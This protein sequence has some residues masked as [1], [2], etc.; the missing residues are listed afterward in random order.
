[1]VKILQRDVILLV[2]VRRYWRK[3]A[4]IPLLLMSASSFSHGIHST[5]TKSST[6]TWTITYYASNP[7]SRLAFRRN[8]DD[9][10]TRRWKPIDNS[11]QIVYENLEEF[12]TRKDGRTF[13]QVSF[14]LTPTYTQ[15]P[16]DYAPFSPYSD[17]GVLVYSGRFFACE[18]KCDDLLNEWEFKLLAPKNDHVIL[19]GKKVLSEATWTD[20]NSGTN[21]Y[22]GQQ[23]P[24]HT[25]GFVALIDGGL[26]DKIRNS[27]F[28]DIPRLTAYF[29]SR[30]GEIPDGITPSLFASY[31]NKKGS[32]VQGGVLPN[33]IFIHWDKENL[34][35][36]ADDKDFLN[37]LLWTFAHEVAH[38]YQRLNEFSLK[39]SES[40]IY[41]GHAELLA[42]DALRHLYPLSNLYRNTKI[43]SF[44]KRCADSLKTTSL[45]DAAKNGEFGAY[46]T[47][48]FLIH[49]SI[50]KNYQNDKERDASP[51]VTWKLFSS[52]LKPG[53]RTS[54]EAFFDL[55]TKL[56]SENVTEK[57]IHFIGV[58]HSDPNSAIELLLDSE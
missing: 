35:R 32:S 14:A 55:V 23:N 19:H 41:E 13:T 53:T 54:H 28:S 48:G 17:G 51:Y 49:Q 30:L 46:Y 31:S 6:N 52:K 56:T 15:L 1:M 26:P 12:V 8:P 11:F 39:T 21:V 16:K 45:Q 34:K 43:A 7:I 18:N 10:R 36:Y 38:Y 3:L 57:I 2:A 4:V 33:Q 37:D 5:I 9:S 25:N 27:L 58:K 44:R 24:V 22:V 50:S 29:K 47:C 20:S 42:Y 40:W